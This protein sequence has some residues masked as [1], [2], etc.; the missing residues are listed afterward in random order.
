MLELHA[1]A[2]NSGNGVYHEFLIRYRKNSQIVYGIVEGKDDPVFYQGII[3][4]FLPTGW[5]VQLIASGNR[6]NVLSALADFDW[7]RYPRKRICF[8]VDRDLSMFRVVPDPIQDNL[9]VTEKYSIENEAANFGTVQRV[10]HEV[11]NISAISVDDANAMRIAFEENFD[12]F[13][14]AMVPIMCQIV[15][16]QRSGKR[17]VLDKIN[18]KDLFY[19]ASGKILAKDGFDTL[20]KRLLYVSEKVGC[21]LCSEATLRQTEEEFRRLGGKERYIR[22]KYV[23]WFVVEMSL[24]FHREI[25]RFSSRYQ[26]SPKVKLSM[27]QNNAMSVMGPRIRC[28]DSL[29]DFLRRSYC[30]FIDPPVVVQ[31]SNSVAQED[32]PPTILNRFF[33]IFAKKS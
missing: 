23:L 29:S 28:P 17:P 11:L 15:V 27:G 14:E 2:L 9:Y 31:E 5:D 22:G 1:A 13:L 18:P 10:L 26:A 6:N 16:W 24:E 8:F 7:S 33:R 4:S 25:K 12:F 3:E 19:F 32:P 21:D 30:E 20:A